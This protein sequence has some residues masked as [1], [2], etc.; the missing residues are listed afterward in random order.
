MVIKLSLP[1]VDK[2]NRVKDIIVNILSFEWPLTLTQINHKA[3]KEHQCS[4][5]YQ[6]IFKSLNE[7]KEDGIIIK[8]EKG[9]SLNLNW[10]NKLRDFSQ[11]LLARYKSNNTNE[12]IDGIIK[13][14][15]QAN[16][17]VITFDS[18]AKLDKFWLKIKEDYY[19]NL[20]S[21]KEITIWEGKHCW[22]LLVYPER[23]YEVVKDANE[24]SVNSYK[25]C[26]SNTALD[27][28]SKKFYEDSGV[29]FKIIKEKS[30]SDM[31]IFG[32]TVMQVYIPNYIQAEIDN[33]YKKYSTPNQINLPKFIKNVL[34]KKTKIDLILTKN[35]EIAKKLKKAGLKRFRVKS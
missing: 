1:E 15:R 35:E 31:A 25:L 5:S 26:Y 8:Q 29:N 33:I 17:Q 28:W 20:K 34:E 7:L 3:K 13:I 14:K 4:K 19:K 22:W 24:K 23:E 27:K 32:D 9:Y 11:N 6:A 2:S 10:A 18:L 21:K 12:L 30:D 16:V